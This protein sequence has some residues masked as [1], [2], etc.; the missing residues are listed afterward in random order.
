L[1]SSA[2]ALADRSI[3]DHRLRL[4]EINE[5]FEHLREGIGVRQ[6]DVFE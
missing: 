6:V 5:G 3:A 4:E 2:L 1:P